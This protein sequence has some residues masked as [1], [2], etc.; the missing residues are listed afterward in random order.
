MIDANELG[1]D[2]PDPSECG[3]II[4]SV[5]RRRNLRMLTEIEDSWVPL[6]I[7]RYIPAIRNLEVR[8]RK[9]FEDRPQLM[10]Y[11]EDAACSALT[12]DPTLA[13]IVQEWL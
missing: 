4:F 8:P 5:N 12:D 2:E 1:A 9:R 6:G 3:I 11:M 10:K 13:S 7:A